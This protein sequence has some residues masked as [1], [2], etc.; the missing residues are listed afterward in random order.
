MLHSEEVRVVLKVLDMYWC[1]S[2]F[3]TPGNNGRLVH[4]AVLKQSENSGKIFWNKRWGCLSAIQ[5][6]LLATGVK[7]TVSMVTALSARLQDE[8][9]QPSTCSLQYYSAVV[10]I[11]LI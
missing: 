3:H 1:V 7:R 6:G 2:H 11:W 5:Y 9:C 4:L 8:V 10:S